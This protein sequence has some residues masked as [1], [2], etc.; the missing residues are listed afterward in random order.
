MKTKQEALD[1]ITQ[2]IGRKYDFDGYY[3]FQCFDYANAYYNY[4][5]G[6]TLHGDGAKDIPF[7]NDFTG[8]ATVYKNDADFVA[9]PGDIVVWGSQLGNGFGHV[10]VVSS[11]DFNQIVVVEQNWLNGGWTEGPKRGGTGWETATKRV[12]TYHNPQWFIRPSYSQSVVK[13]AAATVKKAAQK[14][15]AKVLPPT[16]KPNINRGRSNEAYVMGTIDSLGAEVRKR[17]GSRATGFNWDSK[18]G[19]SLNLGDVVYIFEIHDGW[20]RIYTGDLS[21]QGSNDWIWLGRLQVSK[22]FK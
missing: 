6:G 2:S 8:L 14:V 1:W 5:T 9:E 20:G 12:H 22:V 7:S 15:K 17:K 13:K 10:A 11:A 19:Y 16:F 4:V 18:A 21:G 3:G